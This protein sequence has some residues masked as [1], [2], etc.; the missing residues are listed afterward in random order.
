MSSSTEKYPDHSISAV[1]TV[2][3]A[4]SRLISST[5]PFW[6]LATPTSILQAASLTVS[7][8]LETGA[9]S[10]GSISYLDS[11][12]TLGSSGVAPSASTRPSHFDNLRSTQKDTP[13]L[14]YGYIGIE[15]KNLPS[16]AC[17]ETS[18]LSTDTYSREYTSTSSPPIPVKDSLSTQLGVVTTERLIPTSVQRLSSTTT[19]LFVSHTLAGDLQKCVTP[20]PSPLAG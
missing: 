16:A 20:A 6:K 19:R 8:A 3:D 15:T 7:R 4:S 14:D 9:A 18:C 17:D 13:Q 1:P 11:R 12:L 2:G 10:T 5:T